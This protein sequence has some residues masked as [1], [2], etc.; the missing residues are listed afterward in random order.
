MSNSVGVGERPPHFG[1][2]RLAAAVMVACMA[3][4]AAALSEPVVIALQPQ[5]TSLNI[6]SGSPEI[7]SNS[8]GLQARWVEAGRHRALF[9][10][11]DIDLLDAGI[12]QLRGRGS[13]VLA[14][15]TSSGV[16]FFEWRSQADGAVPEQ[17]RRTLSVGAGQLARLR[18]GPSQGFPGS[19]LSGLPAVSNDSTEQVVQAGW[20][21]DEHR[22]GLAMRG[23]W[24]VNGGEL[25][26]AHPR[27]WLVVFAVDTRSGETRRVQISRGAGNAPTLAVFSNGLPVGASVEVRAWAAAAYRTLQRFAPEFVGG[28]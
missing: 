7:S 15:E 25:T 19:T 24:R 20:L 1:H 21:S 14:E 10:T 23:Q 22:Y 9:L 13:I 4:G 17:V 27:A 16:S 6:S 11:G 5:A 3:S 2:A 8:A 28:S 18:G 26:S 12:G